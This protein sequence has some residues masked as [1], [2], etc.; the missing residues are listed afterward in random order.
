MTP[1]SSPEL[2]RR[3]FVR[4]VS[5]STAALAGAPLLAAEKI[6]ATPAQGAS[7]PENFVWGAATAAYQIEGAWNEDG[8]GR[9]VWDDL[10]HRPGAIWEGHTGDT[11][12]DHYHRMEADVALMRE[13]GLQAYRFSVS[14]SRVLPEGTG[15]VNAK[16]LEF[17]E[18]LVD[19]LLAAGIQPWLTLFHWDYP[20]A[21]FDRGGWLNPDSP[22]WFADYTQT[23]VDRL[24]DRVR[25][26]MTLNEPQCFVGLGH[27]DGTHA[28]ALKLPFR[29]TL[30]AAHH[31][32]LAHGRAV[33]VIRARAKEAPTIGW[34]PV[35]CVKYPATDDPA[36]VEAARRA[37]MQI[38]ARNFWNNTWWSDPVFLG[39]YPEDGLKL[40]GNDVPK[41]T[42]A[43]MRTIKQP[44]DFYGL[45]IYQGAPV[46]AGRDGA[47]EEVPFPTGYPHTLF[48][49]KVTPPALRWGPKFIYERY[50]TPIVIT[51]NGMSNVDWIMQDGAVHDPQ[52]IDFLQRYLQA[53]R[54]AIADGVDAR[55]YFTWSLM[56]NFEWAEGYKHRFG[57][58][59]VDFETLQRTP[60]DSSRW[61]REVIRSHGRTLG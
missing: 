32:L 18:R 24:G 38:T 23:I 54:Q 13:I 51:E 10:C 59:Y 2:S 8:R 17:Y 40:F 6:A 43:E 35:G 57:L 26:W 53:Y 41:F 52:R 28:P 33:Q 42:E 5:G 61:Y 1:D 47:I 45:N 21:L 60:K 37:T 16:G 56:D 3:G 31:V 55:G 20:S 46:R 49:W 15:A 30:L 36:D 50:K 9:S 14:W 25:H 27:Q 34:A 4:L 44:L 11:A 29:D 7:F 22:N 19:A 12:C 58:V 48:L 39:H